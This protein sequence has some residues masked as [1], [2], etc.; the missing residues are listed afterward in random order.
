MGGVVQFLCEGGYNRLRRA[1][2]THRDDLVVRLCGEVG[3]R[4]SEVMAVRRDGIETVDGT[5]FLDVGDRNAIVPA[6]VAHALEKYVR[7]N[8]AE[9]PLFSVS[10]RRMQMIVKECGDRAATA[11]GDDRFRDVST[12]ELRATHAMGL[13]REG[14]D[15]QVVLAVTAYDRLSALEP[16]VERPDRERIAAAFAG[17]TQSM[18]QPTQLHRTLSV[19]ADVGD[20]LAAAT[21]PVEIHDA[22][23]ARLAEAEGY[24]FVWATEA[25]GDGLVTRA[26][27]GVE[28]ETIDQLMSDHTELIESA[29]EA[30]AVRVGDTPTITLIAVPLVG[31]ETTRGLLGIGTTPDGIGAGERDLL[32]VL[33]AQVGHALAAVE[34]KRWLLADT[35]TELTF[36]ID[37][38]KAPLPATAAALSCTFELNGV[39]PVEEGIL[40][41]VVAHDTTPDAVFDRTDAAD[42]VINGRFVG[43]NNTECLLELTLRR[44]PI[45]TFTEAGGR[46]QSYT[47]DPKR[48]QLVGEVSTDADVRGVVE[49]LTD[50][51]PGVYLKA[52]Q[53][54]ERTVTTDTGLAETLT[55]RQ[56]AVLRSAYFGGYF[57]WPRDSTAEELADSLGVSSPTLHHHLRI[58]QQKL[59]RTII[60]DE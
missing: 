34:R 46:V 59:L 15:P 23:C 39:V 54:G 40:C 52:K 51:F 4:P 8:D 25:T 11:T 18:E 42:A 21:A 50:A 2:R 43:E 28:R 3:L 10:E 7:S 17:D 9:G 14:I 35:V 26:Q 60:E 20:A 33:G 44:S 32:T 30:Q 27:A 31:G 38:A 5:R 41:Y 57:E 29:T 49:T 45:R 13:L 24:R 12:R 56:A 36:G 16:Y 22:V 19:A 58:A 37:S 55:D 48:G 6:A 53:Q 47:V 1:A